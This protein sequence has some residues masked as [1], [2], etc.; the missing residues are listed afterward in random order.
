MALCYITKLVCPDALDIVGLATET[1]IN[2]EPRS[3]D[4]LNLDTRYWTEE[5]EAQA[6]AAQEKSGLLTNLTMFR[7]KVSEFPV[8]RA[9]DVVLP[10]QNPRNKPCPCGSGKKYKRCHGR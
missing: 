1:G 6:R 5:M 9:D 4:A 7:D 2:T 3:E 8:P 10:G